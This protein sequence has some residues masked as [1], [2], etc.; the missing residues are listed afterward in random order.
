M[1]GKNPRRIQLFSGLL[2]FFALFMAA[3]GSQASTPTA[4][5]AAD[6]QQVFRYPM[7]G[8]QDFGT[9]D[10]AL[11][12]DATD[13]Y[14]IQAIFTGLVQFD[15]KG[16]VKDQL[17]AS[18]SVSSDGLTYTF[19]L[20]PNAKFSDGSAITA[21]DVAYSINRA[22]DP[23]TKSPVVSYLSLLKDSDK[24]AS[25]DVKTLIGDSI[26]VTDPGTIKLVISQPAAYFLQTLT[27]PSS[28]V[29]EKKLIEKYGTSWTDHLQEG[30]TAGPFKVQSYSHSTGLIL[31]P[32]SNYYGGK[33][34]LKRLEMPFSGDVDTTYKAYQSKQYDYATVPAAS[35]PQAKTR[36][37]FVRTP[38]LVIRYISMNYLAKPFN[39]IK[40]RQALALAIKKSL[41]TDNVLH[42]AVDP[43]NRLVPAGMYGA[44]SSV[45]GPTGLAT[46]DGDANKAKELLTEGLKEE[47]LTSMPDFTFT[48]YTGSATIKKVVDAV[49]SQWQAV[50]GITPKTNAI[51]FDALVNAQNATI[52]NSSL[53]V[54]I[55]GWQ[56]DYPDPQDWLSIFFG[57]GQSYN[58]NNYGQNQSATATAQQAVQADLKKADVEQ[59]ATKRA[60]LYNTAE[61]KLINDVAWIPL[62]Q[63]ASVVLVNPKLKGYTVDALGITD[64]EDWQN[65]YMTK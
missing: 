36:P 16:N 35:L 18:H 11:V 38:A 55:G 65:I 1:Q 7:E 29:V 6:D 4:G 42:G 40:I 21:S 60:Q 27:Y 52:G 28:Y 41:I 14:A 26:I 49:M 24:I 23:A 51:D 62:Y 34:Q 44:S 22:L 9:L 13:S 25:G 64:P 3:C 33:P 19:K 46:V 48:Y 17:A 63:S 37:D 12:Q 5:K 8:K 50:L 53:Q 47:G 43:T 59:N 32:D 15:D 54:W 58:D 45:N 2:C 61:Q 39:N 30:G 20:K 56:A 10:P 57:K 31:V